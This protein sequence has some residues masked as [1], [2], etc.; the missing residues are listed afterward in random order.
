MAELL[1]ALKA[2]SILAVGLSV[3]MLS[4][5]AAASTRALIIACTFAALFALPLATAM[6]PPLAI[7]MPQT[8]APPAAP[9]PVATARPV[10]IATT[11]RAATIRASTHVPAP[12]PWR[13]IVWTL[14]AVGVLFVG[15]PIAG[16]IRRANDLRR[17]ARPWTREVATSRDASVLL[18]DAITTP[19]TFGF[20]RPVILF[21][22][23]AVAWPEADVRRALVHEREHVRR[24]DWAVHLFARMVCALYWFHPLVWVAWKKLRIESEHACDDAVVRGG[25]QVTYAQQLVTLAER[26]SGRSHVPVLS[27]AG[28]SELST[29]VAAVLDATRRRERTGVAGRVCA[30]TTAALLLGM[31]AAPRLVSARPP[32]RR[33]APALGEILPPGSSD[34]GEED[35]V[36]GVSVSGYLYDPTGNPLEGISLTVESMAFGTPRQPAQSKPFYRETVTDAAG[37]FVFEHM[38]PGFYGLAAPNTDYVP[39]AQFALKA[40]EHAERDL[41]MKLEPLAGRFTVCRDCTVRSDDY[42]VP[43]SI[44]REFERDEQAALTNPVT[45]PEPVGGWSA[46]GRMPEY[47]D[48]IRNTALEGK[49]IVEGR[50]GVAGSRVDMRVLSTTDPRLA[51]AALQLLGAQQWKPAY[52]RGVPLEVPFREEVD[53]VLDVA[54]QR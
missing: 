19:G 20:L 22:A 26:M 24:G 25:D 47:P 2:T 23:A 8:T 16:A 49:V 12:L 3:V 29:R 54:P 44:A 45:G 4:R 40:G 32:Q 7:S 38:P 5:R 48:S 14:W 46:N 21:P 35:R 18:H 10:P 33:D 42:V 9:A 53:F 15:A 11:E 27:M 43:D 36:T 50:I 17:G 28:S 41:H 31:I 34:I 30:V 6:L 1:L 37:H 39:A 13:A 52:V 51:P